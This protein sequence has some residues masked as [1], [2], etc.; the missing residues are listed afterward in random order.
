MI[1]EKVEDLP[2][3][4]DS[5]IPYLFKVFCSEHIEVTVGDVVYPSIWNVVAHNH[6]EN[7]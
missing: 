6:G 7:L 2:Y 3:G 1:I 5:F 4:L